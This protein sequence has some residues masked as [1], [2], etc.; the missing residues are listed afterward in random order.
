MCGHCGCD[1][2]DAIGELRD[3]HFALTEEAHL[4]RRSLADGD[5]QLAVE[6]LA[7]LVTHLTGHVRREERGVFAAL[8]EQGDF[9]AEVEALEGEHVALDDRPCLIA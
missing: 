8:R 9:T 2:V 6:R 5:R 1:G 7:G 4:V 3:E